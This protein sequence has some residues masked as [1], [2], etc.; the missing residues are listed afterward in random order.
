MLGSLLDLIDELFGTG[1]LLQYLQAWIVIYFH[2]YFFCNTPEKCQ[3]FRI[4]LFGQQIDLQIELV[5]SFTKSRL[6]ILADEDEGGEKNCL[7]GDNQCKKIERKWIKM[8]YTRYGIEDDP[9]R[10]PD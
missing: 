7:Q 9:D 1:G 10:E 3:H 4:L 2:S 8:F 5:A 6:V